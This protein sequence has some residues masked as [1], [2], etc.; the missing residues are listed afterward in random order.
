MSHAEKADKLLI[1]PAAGTR[2]AP[3]CRSDGSFLR[4]ARRPVTRRVTS[5]T[6]T[7]GWRRPQTD[8][9]GESHSHPSGEEIVG[10]RSYDGRKEASTLNLWKRYV[11]RRHRKKHERIEAEQA[12]Q[13]ALAGRDVEA[14]VRNVA[15]GSAT[16]Q[17]GMYYEGP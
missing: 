12:R 10:P 2:P 3:P 6:E 7:P 9:P 14:A 8:R 4:H 15:Q 5:S 16:A 11:A 13:K 1:K 17:Q